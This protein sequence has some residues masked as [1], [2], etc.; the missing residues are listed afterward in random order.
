MTL[1]E[2]IIVQSEPE[3]QDKKTDS[4]EKVSKPVRF[5]IKFFTGVRFW[6]EVFTTRQILDSKKYNALDFELKKSW[7]VRFWIAKITARQIWI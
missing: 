6:F 3:K 7:R 4:G 2:L 5:W 1:T